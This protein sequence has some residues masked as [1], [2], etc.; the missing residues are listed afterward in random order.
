LNTERR[1]LPMVKIEKDYVF[2][3]PTESEPVGLVRRTPPTDR[4]PLHVRPELGRRAVRAARPAPTRS[5]TGS[6]STCM[7]RH[8]LRCRRSRAARQD[9]GLQSAPGLDLPWYSSFGSDF[10]YDYHVTLDESVARSSTTTGP[11]RSTSGS[12]TPASSRL[13]RVS[14]P[15]RVAS[16]ASA[17]TCSTPT[18]RTREGREHR[19]VLLLPRRDRAPAGRRNGRAEG[20]RRR[21]AWRRYPISRNGPTVAR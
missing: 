14:S 1:M 4:S 20:P 17:T 7:S 19:R 6:W 16:C 12:A 18:R 2:E 15:A 21:R 13:S 10:N 3:G 11:K 9:R 8:D 5:A